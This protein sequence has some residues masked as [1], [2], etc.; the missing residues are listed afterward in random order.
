MV[1]ET[2]LRRRPAPRCML[3]CT[4]DTHTHTHT[5]IYT[6]PQWV[7]KNRDSFGARVWVCVGGRR[8]EGGKLGKISELFVFVVGE[9]FGVRL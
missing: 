3:P 8:A 5:S 7:Q 2:G 6:H 4:L 1:E 9:A